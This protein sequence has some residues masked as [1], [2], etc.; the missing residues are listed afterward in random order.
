M[1][2]SLFLF[3]INAPIKTLLSFL[4]QSQRRE[5]MIQGQTLQQY[6]HPCRASLETITLQ[7]VCSLAARL[8]H[9]QQQ[10]AK[11]PLW[12]TLQQPKLVLQSI[13]LLIP[14]FFVQVHISA[15]SV[16]LTTKHLRKDIHNHSQWRSSSWTA[17]SIYLSQ[18]SRDPS[19]TRFLWLQQV[20]LHKFCPC[21][22]Q[23]QIMHKHNYQLTAR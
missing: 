3:L 13:W 22:L 7:L 15:L 16:L 18:Q 12:L 8:S 23:E 4:R 14:L 21:Y 17:P 5:K 19:C 1:A 6:L 20:L 9:Q 11:L 10:L 2:N